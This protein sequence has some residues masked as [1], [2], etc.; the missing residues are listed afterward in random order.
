[1]LVGNRETDAWVA[2]YRRDWIRFLVASVGLVAAGF[3]MGPLRTLQGAWYVL[4][5]NQAW[6]PYPDNQPDVA[7]AYMRRFYTLIG[8]PPDAAEAARREVE[9]WRV[10][11]EH[12]HD[13]TV[14]EG[15]LIDALVSLY[16]YV[17]AVDKVD[18]RP[19]ALHRVEAM[20]LSDQWVAGGCRADDPTL[21]K[22]RQ[23]LVASY[24]A[25]HQAVA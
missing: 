23:A 3:G 2:Y 7:R 22:E 19:A 4:R 8:I 17:Y 1:M 13:P 5:A 16:S 21:I 14:S 12:Q 18:I 15:Q 20:T 24:S 6:S 11:R 25:L 9:W 10:H